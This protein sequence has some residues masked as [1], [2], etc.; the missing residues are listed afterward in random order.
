MYCGLL[1]SEQAHLGDGALETN[2][3]NLLLKSR[4]KSAILV[5]LKL[6]TMV[7]YV[8][9]KQLASQVK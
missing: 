2:V 7:N 6:L 4:V 8:T 5:R 9:T 1:L 3:Q